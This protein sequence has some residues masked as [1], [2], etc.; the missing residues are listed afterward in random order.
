LFQVG[1]QAFRIAGVEQFHGAA[2]VRVFDALVVRFLQA[3]G[4][5]RHFDMRLQPWPAC[6]TVFAS[7]SELRIAEGE[8][9][10]EDLVVG[11][12]GESRMKLAEPLRCCSIA[13]SMILQ[14]IL[15]LVLEVVEVGMGREA[16]DG[17]ANVL[18]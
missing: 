17:H 8:V 15:R 10:L 4:E 6:K 12:V 7:N 13:R 5:R 18:S 9:G 3:I 16:L 14:E 1:A 11:G 2:K